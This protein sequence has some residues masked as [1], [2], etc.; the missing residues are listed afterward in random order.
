MAKKELDRFDTN[1]KRDMQIK[2]KLIAIFIGSILGCVVGTLALTLIIFNRGLVTDAESGLDYTI[3]GVEGILTDWQSTLTTNAGLLATQ[4]DIK[5]AVQEKNTAALRALLQTAHPHLDA[6]FAAITSADGTIFRGATI[7]FD[8]GTNLK[9]NILMQEALRGNTAEGFCEFGAIPFAQVSILPIQNSGRIIGT[10]ILGYDISDDEFVQQVR[11]NYNVECTI[12]KDDVRVATTLGRDMIGVRVSNKEVVQTVLTQR[13]AFKGMTKIEGKP[14]FAIYHPIFAAGNVTGMIFVAKSMEVIE[15]TRGNT[16]KVVI[17][18]LGIAVIVIVILLYRFVSWLM[19]RIK[20]VTDFLTDLE[21]GD[22]DLTKRCKLFIRDEIGD[23]IIHFDLFLDKLQEI[24][25]QIKGSK[26]ALSSSGTEMATS[27]E[28]STSIIKQMVSNINGVHDQI[29]EQSQGVHKTA[30]AVDDIANSITHLDEMIETQSSGVE[31]ASSA[32]A[33]MMGNI[34]SVNS[35]VDKMSVSFEALSN[36]AKAGF[37]KQQDVND[38]IKQIEG[39]SAML[40]E[41]NTAISDI[42]EQTNL[43][44]MNAAIEAA[45][46]G[47]AGKGFAVVADEIRKLSETST[48]QSKT[49][50]EQLNNIKEAISEVVSAS[51]ESSAAFSAVSQRIEETDQIVLQIK[52]AMEEQNAGS[53][54]INDALREMNDS[55]GE[56][57]RASKDMASKNTLILREMNLLRDSSESMK[58]SM[59]EMASG[60]HKVGESE[61]TLSDIAGTLRNAINKIGSQIDLFNV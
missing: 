12:L 49:I 42:A 50:G 7:D 4:S 5:E 41:A 40:Q 59:E 18:V 10:V 36:N 52:S 58:Q 56:V 24:V 9:G 25:K 55:T 53:R 21:S 27:M 15:S 37:A 32:I 45:H 14:F 1:A 22:A 11:S 26:D 39:Q 60:A 46:A 19:W 30:D 48:A 54:Q 31:E 29:N 8:E 16:L 38:K 6:D 3:K 43:L 47:E 35:S 44:A 28:E 33:Q 20:N 51:A 2:T 61:N 13:A 34:A 17:P 23:L 57:Q